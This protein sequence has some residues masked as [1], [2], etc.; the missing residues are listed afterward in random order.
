MFDYNGPMLWVAQIFHDAGTPSAKLVAAIDAVVER[1]RIDAARRGH[2][3]TR[4]A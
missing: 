4:R 3:R 2:A 1:L